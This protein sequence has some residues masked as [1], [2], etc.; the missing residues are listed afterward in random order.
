M[1]IKLSKYLMPDKLSAHPRKRPTL[2][3]ES[4]F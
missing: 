2:I 4:M 3:L 1:T